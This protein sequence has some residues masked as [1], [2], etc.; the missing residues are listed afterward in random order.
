MMKPMRRTR[1]ASALLALALFG[2]LACGE[3]GPR[4]EESSAPETKNT[5]RDQPERVSSSNPD[6]SSEAPEDAAPQFIV[7]TF[8][9][10]SFSLAEQRGTPVVLN[11]WESW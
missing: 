10:D 2:A 7:E 1:W 9:G 8:D 11:F 3:S 5:N 4:L 6:V